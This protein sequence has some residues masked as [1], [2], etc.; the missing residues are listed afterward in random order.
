MKLLLL[1][2]VR[3]PLPQL[4]PFQFPLP[5]FPGSVT[6]PP[7]LPGF[8]P[9]IVGR[10]PSGLITP[11]SLSGR[12]LL[13]VPEP[14][15]PGRLGNSGRVPAPPA[16]GRL[17]NSGRVPAPPAPGRFAI[18][19]SGAGFVLG[20][21]SP[22]KGLGFNPP[23]EGG[24]GRWM[25]GLGRSG[26][27][28]L[29]PGSLLLTPGSLLVAPGSWPS[30]CGKFDP[31]RAGRVDGTEL[32]GLT[33]GLELEFGKLGRVDGW[34]IP[35]AG[36]VCPPAFGSDGGSL[37]EGPP[38]PKDGRLFPREGAFGG[39]GN[40]LGRDPRLGAGRLRLGVCIG[41]LGRPVLPREGRLVGICGR[42]VGI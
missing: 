2:M 17:G 14:P 41:L 19:G 28:L 35:G 18:P 16:P 13:A 1:L 33:F 27:L 3:F 6:A 12:W 30:S 36:R 23:I 22:G 11:G 40:V 38:I 8:Q 25:P 42:L 26:S 32:G 7:G 9:P 37:L 39:D 15:K 29:A 4:P 20:F 10:P 5:M 31:G 34:P 21:K 24:V